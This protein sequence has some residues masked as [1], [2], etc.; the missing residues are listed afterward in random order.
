[1]GLHKPA[2]GASDSTDTPVRNSSGVLV[3]PTLE[4]TQP[5]GPFPVGDAILTDGLGGYFIGPTF[6]PYLLSFSLPAG[7]DAGGTVNCE[8]QGVN[9]SVAG[10]VIPFATSLIAITV[11]VDTAVKV[12]H[13]YDIE[14]VSNPAG[15]PVVLATLSLQPQKRTHFQRN[16]SVAVEAGTE[17]GARIT[18]TSGTLASAF[19]TG[20]VSIELEA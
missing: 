16:L 5:G 18:Q 12:A 1:M 20:L 9:T 4:V 11:S 15:K 17:L 19:S 2:G 3:D 10:I 7:I 6:R 8:H 13:A 14:I